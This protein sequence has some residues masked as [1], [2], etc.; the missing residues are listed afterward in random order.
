PSELLLP[1]RLF[2][3][4]DHH[5]L[6][7]ALVLDVDR[8]VE[9]HVSVAVAGD[10]GPGRVDLTALAAAG[11]VDLGAALT[12][13]R[14]LAGGHRAALLIA[15]QATAVERPP[16]TDAQDLEAAL[17]VA[18]LARELLHERGGQVEHRDAGVPVV[19][20]LG[21]TQVVNRSSNLTVSVP[22]HQLRAERDV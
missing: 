16:R 4:C 17:D 2:D 18:G 7:L 11:L 13:Q 22:E 14:Q 20:E 1:L 10:A 19:D 6:E 9:V 5:V 8:T 21:R 12:D 15:A 3:G